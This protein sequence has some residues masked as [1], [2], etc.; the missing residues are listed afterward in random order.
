MGTALQEIEPN[1]RK[2]KGDRHLRELR[3]IQWMSEEPKLHFF[4]ER[5]T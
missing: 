2:V 4:G 3:D 1:L 5:K